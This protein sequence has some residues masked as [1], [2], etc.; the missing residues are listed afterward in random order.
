MD[1][2]KYYKHYEVLQ[3]LKRIGREL[4]RDATYELT[5]GDQPLGP[6]YSRDLTGLVFLLMLSFQH[7][8]FGFESSCV[9]QFRQCLST[10]QPSILAALRKTL[11]GHCDSNSCKD[12]HKVRTA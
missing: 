1:S 6:I 9:C 3:R 12:F 4:L 2:R 10:I 8:S 5:M 11:L 7:A